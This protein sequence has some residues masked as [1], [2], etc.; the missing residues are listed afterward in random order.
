MKT[1]LEILHQRYIKGD[2]KRLLSLK[3]ERFKS[4]VAQIWYDIRREKWIS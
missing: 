3:I 2:R 4:V 1:A